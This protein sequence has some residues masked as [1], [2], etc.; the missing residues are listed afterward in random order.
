MRGHADHIQCTAVADSAPAGRTAHERRTRVGG[1]ADGLTPVPCRTLVGEQTRTSGFTFQ[2]GACDENM[3]KAAVYELAT[4]PLPLPSRRSRTVRDIE[5]PD[6]ASSLRPHRARTR[7]E[8]KDW[9]HTFRRPENA[10]RSPIPMATGMD[11][12]SSSSSPVIATHPT[13][14][15]KA[16][17]PNPKLRAHC[18]SST[19]RP[20]DAGS[21]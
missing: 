10:T 13:V 15:R 9:P 6:I 19:R 8:R 2:S 7:T 12:S 3:N 14:R 21:E 17:R 11:R 20:P 16:S 18:V 1:T 5:K 4:T